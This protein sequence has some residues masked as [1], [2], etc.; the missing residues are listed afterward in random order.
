MNGCG[1]KNEEVQTNPE[2]S[3]MSGDKGV[4]NVDLKEGSFEGEDMG[5]EG[6]GSSDLQPPTEEPTPAV[7][8]QDVFFDYDKYDLSDE[9]RTTLNQDGRLLRDQK[10]VRIL[11]EGHCDERGTVQYNLA[12]G[13]KRAKEAKAY[14]VDLGIASTRIDV[15]SYGKEKPFALGHDEAAW[16]QNR[17]AHL[18]VR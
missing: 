7:V 3:G 11:I 5:N 12:L 15:V 16:M 18:V 10:D 2:E 8:L 13:E 9:A 17:R 6:A 14:L 4:D 1:K